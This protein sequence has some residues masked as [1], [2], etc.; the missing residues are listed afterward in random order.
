M[1]VAD[2]SAVPDIEYTALRM[3]A[4]LE[5]ELREQGISLWLA[6]LNPEPLAVIQR[7]SLGKLLGRERMFFNLEQAVEAYQERQRG[8]EPSQ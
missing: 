4:E 5:E 2:L 6:A 8:M 7:S 3:L 1:L